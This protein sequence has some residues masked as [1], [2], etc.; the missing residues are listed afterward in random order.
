MRHQGRTTT[1]K[2]AN[3][4]PSRDISDIV[5]EVARDNANGKIVVIDLSQRIDMTTADFA[6]LLSLRRQLLSQDR[7]LR[8]T[9]L[10]GRSWI[11]YDIYRLHTALPC[12]TV[13]P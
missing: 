9:G 1:A 2:S 5:A 6:R 3:D 12:A 8:I 4:S 7:D 13:G 10:R 11:L